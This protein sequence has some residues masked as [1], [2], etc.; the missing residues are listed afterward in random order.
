MRS[1]YS[2]VRKNTR[3]IGVKRQLKLIKLFAKH[4][5]IKVK[6]NKELGV[7][8]HAEFRTYNKT[9]VLK[10]VISRNSKAPLD[11]FFHEL[12]H[13]HCAVNRLWSAYHYFGNTKKLTIAQL[14]THNRTAIKAERWV[15]Y[16][17]RT[18]KLKWFPN[19]GYYLSYEGSDG[20]QWLH[21]NYLLFFKLLLRKKLKRRCQ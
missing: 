14:Q 20:A 7:D 6:F 15:D 11:V 16:W 5:K 19:T 12:G 17:G 8:G 9:G 3:T 13:I 2:V 4:Y 18:E 21:E 1:I 10:I